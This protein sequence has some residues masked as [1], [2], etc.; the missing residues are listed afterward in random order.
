MRSYRQNCALA[1]ALDVLGD[2]WTLL[3]IREL[4]IRE[5]CRYTDLHEG[6]PGIATNLLSDR[7]H[8]LE[9]QGVVS[10]DFAPPPI[11]TIL[12]RLTPRGKAI[13][14]VIAALGTW[15]AP[16]LNGNPDDAS[17]DH[18]VV[19]PIRLYVRDLDPQAPPIRIAL[20]GGEEFFT[21]TTVGDGTVQ[22]QPGIPRD[23]DARITGSP[24]QILALLA[25]KATLADL[26]A[27]GLCFE[28]DP[29]I[30]NRFAGKP[31]S[32]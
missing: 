6:L 32:Q 25:G 19:L 22:A 26:Q 31:S 9:Q 30:L 28:G 16:L 23:P 4:L 12:Y 27:A 7:L 21:L 15:G 8:E 2:R 14:P 24:H 3:I 29:A 17:R 5:A 1:K 11:A 10:H 13:E 20:H 18:W